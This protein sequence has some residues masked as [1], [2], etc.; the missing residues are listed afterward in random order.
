MKRK[1]WLLAASA[2]LL[3]VLAF[4]FESRERAAMRQQ[5]ARLYREWGCGTCHGENAEGSGRGPAL[6]AL[7]E[8]WRRDTLLAYL[9]DPT[10]VRAREE[11]LQAMA[12]RF[13]P[14]SMPSF[15]G[16]NDAQLRA[17]ADYVLLH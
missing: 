12:R 9:R 3:G 5:G 1:Y 16:L 6:R 17:L 2:A 15:E 10:I 11:R 7:S 13:A 14:L 8:H 4:V